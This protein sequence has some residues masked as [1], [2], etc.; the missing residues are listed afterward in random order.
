MFFC[1]VVTILRPASSVFF[2]SADLARIL[3]D[4]YGF[5]LVPTFRLVMDVGWFGVT[6][7]SIYVGIALWSVKPNAV[8]AAKT[9]LVV[10]FAYGVVTDLACL[11]LGTSVWFRTPTSTVGTTVR[12]LVG[13]AA[14][15][16]T[17]FTYFRESKRV[18]ATYGSLEPNASGV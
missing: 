5:Q 17:W 7:F 9:L 8:R 12:D 16:A 2:L 6:A 15:F 1:V 18:K 4:W 10:M 3:T 13:S 11:S 14:F